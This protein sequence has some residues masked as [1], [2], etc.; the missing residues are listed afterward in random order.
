MLWWCDVMCWGEIDSQ[1]GGLFLLGRG[2]FYFVCLQ[3]WSVIVTGSKNSR[4]IQQSIKGKLAVKRRMKP[5]GSSS[6]WE[7]TSWW[8]ERDEDSALPVSPDGGELDNDEAGKKKDISQSLGYRSQLFNYEWG[9][10]VVWWWGRRYYLSAYK[11]FRL[12]LLPHPFFPSKIP[13]SSQL[14]A[15][16]LISSFFTLVFPFLLRFKFLLPP[17]SYS[18]LFGIDF[19]PPP[20]PNSNAACGDAQQD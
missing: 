19:W 12:A 2:V 3:K 7:N 11:L 17:F 15:F 1:Q 13:P 14:W 6:G 16:S 18:L 10:N 8:G 20:P 5:W 4:W 9:M